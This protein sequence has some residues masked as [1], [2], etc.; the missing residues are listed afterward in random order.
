MLAATDASPQQAS[1]GDTQRKGH[2]LQY[3]KHV[4]P[5]PPAASSIA[6]HTPPGT[7]TRNPP[8]RTPTLH[9]QVQHLQ[10]YLPLLQPLCQH[11]GEGVLWV[12]LCLQ[13]ARLAEERRG[14]RAQ[15]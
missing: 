9:V 10:R 1:I 2:P 11:R 7:T 3:S 8:T 12:L 15:G 4:Q 6:P 13:Y 5:S 14:E